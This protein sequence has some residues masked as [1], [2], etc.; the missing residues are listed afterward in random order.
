M[1]AQSFMDC[2]LYACHLALYLFSRGGRQLRVAFFRLAAL[3]AKQAV[4]LR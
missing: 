4:R 2:G 3:S 1:E